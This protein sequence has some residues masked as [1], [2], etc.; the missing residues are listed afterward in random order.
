MTKLKLGPLPDDKP[1]KVTL[2]LPAPLQPRSGR[3]CQGAGPGCA[4]S[5]SARRG[6]GPSAGGEFMDA[7][8]ARATSIAPAA[9]RPDDSYVRSQGVQE[10]LQCG[11]VVLW[12]PAGDIADR[13]RWVRM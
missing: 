13:R 4:A 7:F 12:M 5:P 8:I 6:C 1:V 11:I 9:S 2:E 10:G 3:L